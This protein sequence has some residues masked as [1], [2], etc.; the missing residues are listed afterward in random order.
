MTVGLITSPL[1]FLLV[2]AAAGALLMAAVSFAMSSRAS[3]RATERANARRAAERRETIALRKIITACDRDAAL[4]VVRRIASE[5]LY[6]R[7]TALHDQAP[8]IPEA[9]A[10]D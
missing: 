7:A 6:P 10:H 4:S 9:Q 8:I 2:G 1:P 3:T 5:A